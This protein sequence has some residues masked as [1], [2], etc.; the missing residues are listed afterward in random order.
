MSEYTLNGQ[1]QAWR[2]GLSVAALL[3]ELERAPDAVATALNGAFLPRGR[4]EATLIQ[5]GDALT[6]IQPITGG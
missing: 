4:R 3:A 2:E 5:P 6:L 1:A